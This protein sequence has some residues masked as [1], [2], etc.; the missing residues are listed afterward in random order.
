MNDK[1]NRRSGFLSALLWLVLLLSLGLTVYGTATMFRLPHY[2]VPLFGAYAILGL[3]AMLGTI[4]LMRGIKAGL[5]LTAILSLVIAVLSLAQTGNYGCNDI[6]SAIGMCMLALV[7]LIWGLIHIKLGGSSPWSRMLSGWDYKHC[8]HLYQ[9]FCV[10]GAA[11]LLLTFLAV[12]MARKAAETRIDELQ[13]VVEQELQSHNEEET[14]SDLVAWTDTTATAS[15]PVVDSLATAKSE[16][17]SGSDTREKKPAQ[18]SDDEPAFNKAESLE[19]LKQAIDEANKLFP[20]DTGV[21]IVLTRMYMSGDYVMYLA[22]CDESKINVNM[23]EDSQENRRNVLN[24]LKQMVKSNPQSKYFIKACISAGKGIG[25]HYV[26]D[27]TGTKASVR[28][29][30]SMLKR[31]F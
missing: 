13:E 30:L 27:Q 23:I 15:E 4:L 24:T 10:I 25:Y 11:V 18:A 22:E 3:A 31:T 21:G 5:Y 6:V 28:I 16:K 17:P 14:T 20:Q 7:M 1:P 8:R 29:P 12:A 19:M 2:I 9:V 26:G